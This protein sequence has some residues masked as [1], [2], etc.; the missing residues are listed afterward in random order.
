MQDA[1]NVE[2]VNEALTAKHPSAATNSLNHA[3]CSEILFGAP[4]DIRSTA[5]VTGLKIHD[6]ERK[7]LEAP[8]GAFE[9]WYTPAEKHASF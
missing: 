5:Q 1:V 4:G 2:F 7:T 3:S 9:E 8:R 6:C